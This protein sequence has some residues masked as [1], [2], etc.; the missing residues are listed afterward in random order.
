MA[1][2]RDGS[3]G[4]YFNNSGVV[5][6]LTSTDMTNLNSEDINASVT[7]AQGDSGNPYWTGIVF[8]QFRNLQGFYTAH[9]NFFTTNG[10]YIQTSV[11]T[12]NGYDG[13]WTS[14]G[15]F[16]HNSYSVCVPNY[17][18]QQ[19]TLAVNGIKAVRLY[20]PAGD[21]G[22]FLALRK[23]H[24]YGVYATGQTPDRVRMWH[25]TTDNPL[26]ATPAAFEYG[27][28]QRGS[29]ETR[30]FRVKNT[31]STKTATGTV[32]SLAALTDANPSLV[33]A[34]HQLSLDNLNWSASV[35]IPTLAP[36]AISGT[37]YIRR[38]TSATAALSVWTARIIVAPGSMS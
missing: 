18:T 11:D 23:L 30:L 3:A 32:I 27:D 20:H 4:F 28:V 16:T 7:D 12:T 36:G 6:Q 13:T 37:I 19:Q 1:Y 2:D 5:G 24:L 38:Q 21:G 10:Y 29:Q 14:Q 26:S 25:P 22:A 8:P 35:T 9:G 17:R 31:S 15:R 33:T 34:Q